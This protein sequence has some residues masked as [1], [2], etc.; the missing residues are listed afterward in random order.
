MQNFQNHFEKMI[1]ASDEPFIFLDMQGRDLGSP[2]GRLSLIQL[3]LGTT[4]Y[5]VDALSYPAAIPTLKRYLKSPHL[6][7]YVWDGRS[8]YSELQHEHRVTLKGVVNLQ[9]IYLHFTKQSSRVH[10][11]T[12]MLDA[13]QQLEALPANQFSTIRL[14]NFQMPSEAEIP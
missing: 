13:S 3:G 10:R 11:L 5:L 14:S 1:S 12:S 9:L 6:H 8:D 2:N 7:K 4:T